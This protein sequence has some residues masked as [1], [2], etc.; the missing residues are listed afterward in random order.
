MANIDKLRL[1]VLASLA[2]SISVTLRTEFSDRAPDHQWASLSFMTEN[3]PDDYMQRIIAESQPGPPLLESH[4]L[5]PPN[6][7]GKGLAANAVQAIVSHTGSK[8]LASTVSS[9]NN[10]SKK[11]AR[12][13]WQVWRRVVI[14]TAQGV[15]TEGSADER[16]NQ[17]EKG[18]Q[19]PDQPTNDPVPKRAK[20]SSTMVGMLKSILEGST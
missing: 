5:T 15:G 1:L 4:Y 14:S 13:A 8:T 20:A 11:A 19:P 16:E 6:I 18:N 2:A 12:Q 3:M 9:K 7:K 10:Q 17:R